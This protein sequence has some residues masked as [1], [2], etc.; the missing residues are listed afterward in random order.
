VVE[1]RRLKL[2]SGLL[3][4]ALGVEL[5]VSPDRLS[6]LGTSVI[7]FGASI[8]IWLAAVLVDRRRGPGSR[9]PLETA[10][11]AGR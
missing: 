2:L 4:L 8:G 7:V 6:D 11:A 5:L 9:R 1:A 10:R 3:M